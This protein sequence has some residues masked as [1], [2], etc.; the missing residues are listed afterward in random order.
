LSYDQVIIADAA[1]GNEPVE[2]RPLGKEDP[3]PVS[4]S[5]H[6]NA[7]MLASLAEQLYQQ[8][9]PIMICAVKGESFEMSEQLSPTAKQN[10]DRAIGII[11][12]W[13]GDGCR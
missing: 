7:G 12:K 2:F 6:I 5:H 1:I 8:T 10:A 9:L 4:T 13:I 3:G 11:C